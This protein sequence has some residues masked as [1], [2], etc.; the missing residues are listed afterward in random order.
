MYSRQWNLIELQK[1]IPPTL[2]TYVLLPVPCSQYSGDSNFDWLFLQM[3][4]EKNHFR[5][6]A[7]KKYFAHIHNE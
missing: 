4:M 2:T 1:I 3:Q 6:R 5:N 7:E